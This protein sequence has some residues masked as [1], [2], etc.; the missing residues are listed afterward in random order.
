M[1]EYKEIESSFA[2]TWARKFLYVICFLMCPF[3]TWLG[4]LSMV[5][6][7]ALAI[8]TKRV[9]MFKGDH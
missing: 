8:Y 7:F 9:D 4:W 2:W 5:G 6:Y 3:H 1:W